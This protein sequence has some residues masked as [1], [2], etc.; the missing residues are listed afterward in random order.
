MKVCLIAVCHGSY[1]EA[2]L[3][4]DS[5]EASLIGSEI[6]LDIY[7]VENSS[8][9]D[10]EMI[11]QIK[12]RCMNSFFHYVASEN[13]GYFPSAAAAIKENNIISTDYD[14]FIISNVDLIISK[15]FFPTLK[16]IPFCKN[17]GVY[18]PAILS[19]KTNIDKNP[20]ITE[21]PTAYKLRLNLF[22]FRR[23][24]TYTLLVLFNYLRV[25]LTK[26]IKFI[27]KFT[28]FFLHF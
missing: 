25:K 3:F 2:L 20:K 5:I 27:F 14:Y 1:E 26:F 13:I 21:R 16:N 8:K 12:R 28:I 11:L 24:Q 7:F 15:S 22:L 10:D 18:A 4:L 9:F 6:E 19:K 17:I 23:A